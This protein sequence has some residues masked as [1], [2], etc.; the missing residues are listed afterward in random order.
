[1]NQIKSDDLFEAAEDLYFSEKY[2]E[3][4]R[5]CKTG[6]D[7]GSIACLRLLGWLYYT[8]KGCD[9]DMSVALNTFTQAAEHGDPEAFFGMGSVY[10]VQQ[11]YD[12]SLAYYK[13]AADLGFVPAMVR[14]GLMY[15][16]ALG[17]DRDLVKAKEYYVMADSNGSLAGKAAYAGFLLHGNEGLWG[18]IKSLP[19]YASL[20]VK[21]AIEAKNDPNSRAFMH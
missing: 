20:L 7:G 3:A 1:M 16:Q 13:K 12:K 17:C 5:A 21:A 8:G 2:D 11:E 19:I 14:V 10:Y 9:K 15:K 4:Y 18:R 6:A